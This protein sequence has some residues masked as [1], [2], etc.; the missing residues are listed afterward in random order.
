MFRL[1]LWGAT[2]RAATVATHFLDYPDS[3]QTPVP[4]SAF[5]SSGQQGAPW[6]LWGLVAG[7]QAPLDDELP[8]ASPPKLDMVWPPPRPTVP[9]LFP[10]SETCG[11]NKLCHSSVI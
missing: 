4:G 2:P 7:R 3:P 5:L 10:I 6:Q 11:M 9:S 1:D 8:R